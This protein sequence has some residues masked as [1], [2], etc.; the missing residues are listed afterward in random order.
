MRTIVLTSLKGGSGKSTIAA[1]VAVEAERQGVGKVAIADTDAPQGSASH[2]W[3]A[4]SAETPLFARDL[5]VIC[6]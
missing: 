3:N 6:P 1:N 4:R 5:P 2:W